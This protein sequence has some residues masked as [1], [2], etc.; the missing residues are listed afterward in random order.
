MEQELNVLRIVLRNSSTSG[1]QG[2][3]LCAIGLKA[4]PD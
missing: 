1:Q 3:L 4:L 2:A